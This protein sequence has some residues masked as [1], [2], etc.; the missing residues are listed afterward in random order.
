MQVDHIVSKLRHRF[1]GSTQ[2]EID[3]YI[4]LNP[5]CRECNF[6]K[7]A[8]GVESYRKKIVSLN[9]RVIQAFIV[10]LAIK[11]KLLSLDTHDVLFY[12]E[13]HNKK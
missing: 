10:R 4:N 11:Y 13:K 3:D 1:K 6:Y 7:G 12:F 9:E 5:S 8:M 2:V